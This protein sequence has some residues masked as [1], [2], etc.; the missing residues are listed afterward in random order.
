LK[1]LCTKA[2]KTIKILTS[3]LETEKSSRVKAEVEAENLR[4]LI[5]QQDSSSPSSPSLPTMGSASVSPIHCDS[6]TR[7]RTN[8]LRASVMSEAEA[9][10]ARVDRFE[11]PGSLSPG[12]QVSIRRYNR[13]HPD[14]VPHPSSPSTSPSRGE[15]GVVPKLQNVAENLKHN[16]IELQKLRE[17]FLYRRGRANS[18]TISPTHDDDRSP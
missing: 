12:A 3:K 2:E 9:L 6:P 16:D 10:K 13:Q 17:R 18:S 7:D 5:E 14:H 15:A 1:I 4:I 11:S 8:S